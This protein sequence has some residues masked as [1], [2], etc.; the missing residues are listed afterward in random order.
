MRKELSL[1][2]NAT[3]SV[4]MTPKMKIKAHYSHWIK[5]NFLA[6]IN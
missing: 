3:E 5:F 2:N 4:K 1:L 6:T